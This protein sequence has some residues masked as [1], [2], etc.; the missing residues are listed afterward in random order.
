MNNLTPVPAA[1]EAD[2]LTSVMTKTLP[3]RIVKGNVS[4][5]P[6][7]CWRRKSVH[8]GPEKL[9]QRRET[10]FAA[11]WPMC[12]SKRDRLRVRRGLAGARQQRD[13]QEREGQCEEDSLADL[14]HASLPSWGEFQSPA[15]TDS[16]KLSTVERFFSC[17]L[18]QQHCEIIN[19]ALQ[20][21]G[22]SGDLFLDQLARAHECITSRILLLSPPQSRIGIPKAFSKIVFPAL[23]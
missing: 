12:V 9:L 19:L 2:Q 20:R 11:G 14:A 16:L 5:L 22:Q 23:W 3:D 10:M 8:T 21:F 4:S 6:S 15:R 18:P 13:E 17:F 1:A 7:R